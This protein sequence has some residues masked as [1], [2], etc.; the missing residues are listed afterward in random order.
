MG[1]YARACSRAYDFGGIA[2]GKTFLIC[3]ELH[4]VANMSIT[5]VTCMY[6][7]D[8][9]SEMRPN[10]WLITG[11]VLHNPSNKEKTYPQDSVAIVGISEILK[12]PSA[13][14]ASQGGMTIE[15]GEGEEE[16]LVR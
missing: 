3:P 1:I 7:T 10:G 6:H 12:N 15:E 8:L 9:A 14:P 4:P 16:E 11:L 2:G 5:G 13:P